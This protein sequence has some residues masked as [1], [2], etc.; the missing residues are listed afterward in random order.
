VT[1]TFDWETEVYRRIENGKMKH[2]MTGAQSWMASG[3]EP[4]E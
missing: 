2:E 1:V 3:W 4:P